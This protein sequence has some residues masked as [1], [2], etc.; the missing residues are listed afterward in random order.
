MDFER[1]KKKQQIRGGS[2]FLDALIQR[3][4]RERAICLEIK[5]KF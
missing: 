3:R 4:E 5:E 2:T 1:V